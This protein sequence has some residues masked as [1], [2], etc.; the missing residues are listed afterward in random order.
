MT[1]KPDHFSHGFGAFMR[2]LAGQKHKLEIIALCPLIGAGVAMGLTWFGH[3]AITGAIA[4]I[5][6]A[7][8]WYSQIASL[9]KRIALAGALRSLPGF[10]FGLVI[11]VSCAVI[12]S[13]VAEVL[14]WSGYPLIIG[15]VAGIVAPFL[16][17]PRI[18]E[19]G[20]GIVGDKHLRGATLA[21]E[22][23]LASKAQM[24][25]SARSESGPFAMLGG[26]PI[27]RFVEPQNFLVV[28]TVGVGKTTAIRQLLDAAEA[29]H[30][31]AIVYD[32]KGDMVATY[33]R[34]DRGDV[35]L[36]PYDSRAAVWDLFA[37]VQQNADAKLVADSIVQPKQGGRV[38]EWLGYLSSYIGDA[39][40]ALKNSGRGS[41]E[42]LIRALQYGDKASLAALVDGLPSRR[43]F[44][45]G[46]ERATAS[47]VFGSP[48]AV[49]ILTSLR[50]S[51]GSGGVFSWT[52]WASG[53]DKKA[54]ARPWVFL[55][56]PARQAKVVRP[57][58]TAALEV[59]AANL[60]SLDPNIPR[61]VWLVID[62]FSSLPVMDAVPTLAD[63]GRQYGYS[64]VIGIQSPSQLISNYGESAADTLV[65][66]AGTQLILGLRGGSA[67]R[68]ACTQFGR[69]EVER[70]QENDTFDTEEAHARSN[71]SVSREVRDLVLDSEIASLPALHGFLRVPDVGVGRVVIPTAHLNRPLD[72]AKYPADPNDLW[73]SHMHGLKN[74]ASELG[75]GEGVRPGDA[76]A[77]RAA[78]QISE[79][80]FHL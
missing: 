16:V 60:L 62:E 45:P 35:I 74:S 69:Q 40:W 57:L 25:A 70:R 47:V 42:E 11:L 34:A 72:Q 14:S 33:Y 9:V 31:A 46:A 49:R 67:A 38:N 22:E 53:I 58:I 3:A 23:A 52:A 77:S 56:A 29:R 4:G 27:P 17:L 59:A 18:N 7:T 10:K 37:D 68:W 1:R 66:N 63:Q 20:E 21:T 75:A 55:G 15:A 12:G 36:N 54:D 64:L 61:R 5:A 30:E 6:V 76:E 8:F 19:L 26:V 13:V 65:N 43:Y 28:G 44:E 32:P 50:R 39:I 24:V 2:W 80:D 51:A 78:T 48:D 41:T 71:V 79:G 73:L